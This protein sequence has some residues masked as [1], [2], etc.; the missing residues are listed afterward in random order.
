MQINGEAIYN[1]T[2]WV[3]TFSLDSKSTKVIDNSDSLVSVYR[4]VPRIAEV[5][6][7][8]YTTRT[9]LKMVYIIFKWPASNQLRINYDSLLFINNQVDKTQLFLLDKSEMELSW[10]LEDGKRI[11]IS[12]P[13]KESLFSKW[14]WTLKIISP[15]YKAAYRNI[16]QMDV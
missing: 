8:C 15:N 11:V 14:C 4:S 12:L 13:E 1:S 9:D 5:L 2:S 6:P 10:E 16:Q 3:Y 7:Y